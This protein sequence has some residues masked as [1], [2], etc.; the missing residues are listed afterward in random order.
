MKLAEYL[1]REREPQWA[2]SQ[3]AGI[4]ESMVSR[5]KLGRICNVS[6]EIAQKIVKATKGKVTL[7]D[8]V[9]A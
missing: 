6:D 4:S 5:I 8:L 7:E 3:R 2:F 9:N 1:T